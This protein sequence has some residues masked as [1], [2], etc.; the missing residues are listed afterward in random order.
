MLLQMY[1]FVSSTTLQ[2]F[3][4]TIRHASTYAPT[5]LYLMQIRK[6]NTSNVTGTTKLVLLRNL[7]KQQLKHPNQPQLLEYSIDNIS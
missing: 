1:S 5:K 6:H 7:L 4:V 2:H 3:P